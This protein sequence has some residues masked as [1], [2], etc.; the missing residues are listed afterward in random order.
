D[1]PFPSQIRDDAQNPPVKDDLDEPEYE[2][3]SILRART[4]N[5]GRGKI[6]QALVKWIGWAEPTWEPIQSIQDTRALDE[7]ENLY[8][9]IKTNDGPTKAKIGGFVGPAGPKIAE[10]RRL[11]RRGKRTYRKG[12]AL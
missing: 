6:R 11:K 12:G 5:R 1:D 8:G 2:V 10:K 3:E 9:S 4:M 7:F